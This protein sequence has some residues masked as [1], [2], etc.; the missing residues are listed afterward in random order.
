MHQASRG[1]IIYQGIS[2]S[3]LKSGKMLLGI[4]D[5]KKKQCIICCFIFP[6]EKLLSLTAFAFCKIFL[7]FWLA[8]SA[9]GYWLTYVMIWNIKYQ[10]R[11]G[12]YQS[13]C[14]ENQNREKSGY[15]KTGWTHPYGI[16]YLNT[17]HKNVRHI[18]DFVERVVLQSFYVITCCVA[19]VPF[20]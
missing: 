4:N 8:P 12:K 11:V 20:S 10:F 5:L 7:T 19:R 16:S 18:S 14:R 2:K 6:F 3:V 9:L 17:C 13:W 1:N 15:F